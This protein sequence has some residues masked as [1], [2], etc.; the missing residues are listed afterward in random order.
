[1]SSWAEPIRFGSAA[2]DARFGEL[3]GRYFRSVHAYCRRRLASDAVDDVVA[4][5]FLTAWRRAAM[6]RMAMARWC[7]CTASPTG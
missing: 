2:E 6:S 4:E 5:V 3:Y 1:M 7:G